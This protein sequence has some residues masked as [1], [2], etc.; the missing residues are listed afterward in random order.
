MSYRNPQVYFADTQAFS[1]GF[2][3][4]FGKFQQKFEEER[5]EK[6]RIAKEQDEALAGAYKSSDLSAIAGLDAR[7]MDGL[8][9]SIDAIITEGSFA[10]ASASEQAKMLRKVSS[11][12]GT[13]G[14]LGEL[15]QIDNKDWD[16]RN[17]PKLG[18]LKAAM[19]RGDK[20]IKIEGKGLDL[21]ITGD[22]GEVSLDELSSAKFMKRSDYEE[23]YKALNSAFRTKADLIFKEAAK[24]GLSVEE[25]EKKLSEQFTFMLKNE[26]SPELWSYLYSNEIS[27]ATQREGGSMYYNDPDV[28]SGFKS[29]EEKDAF[30]DKQ[31]TLMA[32]E[33]G[34]KAIGSVYN[35]SDF[36]A[37][38]KMQ[39]EQER[40]LEYAKI[41]A[42]QTTG[43]GYKPTD[44]DK[45]I[46]G[47]YNALMQSLTTLEDTAWLSNLS[48]MVKNGPKFKQ[49]V[50][51]LLVNNLNGMGFSVTGP[52]IDESSGEITGYNIEN[53]VGNHTMS[54]QIMVR[55][56]NEA[57]VRNVISNILNNQKTKLEGMRNVVRE[58]MGESKQ[59][60]TTASESVNQ[61]DTSIYDE[62]E[63]SQTQALTTNEQKGS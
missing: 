27:S 23:D 13:I 51:A 62:T 45:I 22:F 39:A 18:A 28:V 34:Q 26:D 60:T 42:S 6:E 41:R 10:T 43:S 40:A 32:N 19:T 63:P 55:D 35:Y 7:M 53:K 50:D 29:I 17:S 54:N 47:Q 14:R 57:N 5:L 16:M 15:A 48:G 24:L 37:A 38:Y 59:T 1:K 2:E 21:K 30:S 4:S 3:E 56:M 36:A 12:K 25:I 58:M 44:L 49:V 8:Q 46:N 61:I 33:L 11:I 52:V 31:F 9:S 20:S